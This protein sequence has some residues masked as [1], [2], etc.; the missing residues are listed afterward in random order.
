MNNKIEA[1]CR[2]V[3]V[4]SV[5][6]NNGVVLT[7]FEKY[8][9]DPENKRW[10]S[11]TQ[12]WIVDIDVVCTQGRVNNMLP[13]HYLQRLPDEDANTKCEWDETIFMPEDL[14]INTKEVAL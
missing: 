8:Q 1:G 14:K 13:E 12:L 4:N 7:V 10:V 3:I 2:A 6:G 5:D 11:K 9:G